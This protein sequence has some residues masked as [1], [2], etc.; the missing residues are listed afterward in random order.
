MKKFEL[1]IPAYNESKNLKKLIESVLESAKSVQLTSE[2]FNLILVENGSTDN[3]SEVL[4]EILNENLKPWVRVVWVVKNQGYGFGLMSGLKEVNSEYVGWTHADL[5]CDPLNAFKALKVIES[6]EESQRSKVLVKGVRFGRNWKDVFVS[7][8]FETLALLVLGLKVNEMNAQP[9]VFSSKLLSS[10]KNPPKTFA[11]DLYGLYQAQ[12]NGY[13]I[14][15]IDVLFPPRVFG[16][17]NWAGNFFSRYK[18]ILGIIKYM[19]KLLLSEG[20]V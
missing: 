10:F 5:Q 19:F 15:T 12:K 13:K 1:V 9:K 6:L 20:R 4:N 8:V 14:L 3:S 16:V 2:S 11:F 17:S 18:T 7:R